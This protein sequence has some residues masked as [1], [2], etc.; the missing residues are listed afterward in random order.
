MTFCHVRLIQYFIVKQQISM[1]E[2]RDLKIVLSA[3]DAVIRS[4]PDAITNTTCTTTA[5]TPLSVVI[6]VLRML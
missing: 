3:F 2:M 4:L 1:S 6:T 5:S